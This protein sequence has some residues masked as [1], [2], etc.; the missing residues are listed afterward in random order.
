MSH[1]LSEEVR[2]HPERVRLSGPLQ[3]TIV[4]APS[5][6]TDTVSVS[7]R[8]F[9]PEQKNTPAGQA[10]SLRF[11]SAVWEPHVVMS[12]DETPVATV[13]TPAVGDSCLV[14]FDDFAQPWVTSWWAGGLPQ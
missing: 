6:P 7:I 8:Q 2:R 4:R 12:A 10:T 11:D 13:V 5:G 9:G 1:Y 14:A 3:A